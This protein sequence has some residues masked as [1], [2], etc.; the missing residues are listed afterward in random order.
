MLPQ[1]G[2]EL[3]E[4][5]RLG[6]ENQVWLRLE[7]PVAGPITVRR[8]VDMTQAHLDT[9]IWQIRTLRRLLA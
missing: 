3:A 2:R 8:T 6:D 1:G 7:H 4:W 5:R 9:H